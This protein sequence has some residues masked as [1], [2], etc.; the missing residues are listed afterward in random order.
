MKKR[1]VSAK[2][3]QYEITKTRTVSLGRFQIQMDSI[4]KGGRRYPYSFIRMQ[5]SV[6]ILPLVGGKILLIRQYRHALK[7][8]IL[9]IPGGAVSAGERPAAAARRELLEETG[10]RAKKIRSLGEYYPSPGSA[11]EVCHLYC[12]EC[13]Q[14]QE[15]QREPLELIETRL[16][17]AA[18]LEELI[19]T[20]RFR[21]S[22][23]L[24][25]WLKYRAVKGK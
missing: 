14:Y 17:T 19:A 11:D 1:P 22:M 23:G 25:A 15:P 24:V 18:E 7:K 20:G 3:P 8:E 4:R 2:K 5:Q 21:H 13:G 9:E 10:F 6:G 12:A 16:V